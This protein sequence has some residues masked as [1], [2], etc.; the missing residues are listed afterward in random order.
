MRTILNVIWLVLCGIWMAIGYAI[1]GL[2]CVL[3]YVLSQWREHKA[4]Q[5]VCAAFAHHEVR[6]QVA[7]RP[8]LAQGGCIRSR[9]A[10]GFDEGDAFALDYRH[11]LTIGPRCKGLPNPTGF[12]FVSAP[13]AL[14]QTGVCSQNRLYEGAERAA[15]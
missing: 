1:A 9:R 10:Q 7:G 13:N 5:R 15:L 2:V 12:K 8:A 4:R 6:D 3:L 14:Q 11:A